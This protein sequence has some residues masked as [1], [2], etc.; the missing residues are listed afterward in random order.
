M[1]RGTRLVKRANSTSCSRVTG[2]SVPPLLRNRLVCTQGGKITAGGAP[3][4]RILGYLKRQ[5]RRGARAVP[6]SWR[7]SGD[8]GPVAA[9]GS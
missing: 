3:G 8:S 5:P 9:S 7:R 2:L 1:V 4:L 6:Q